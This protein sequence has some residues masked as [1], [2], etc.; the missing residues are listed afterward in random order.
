MRKNIAYPKILL[1]LLALSGFYFANCKTA[2]S[3]PSVIILENGSY[4]N[5]KEFVAFK[6]IRV[7]DGK[8]AAINNAISKEKGERINVHGKYVIPGL[9]DA[10]VHI[11]GSPAYPYVMIDHTNNLKSSLQCGLTTVVDLFFPEDGCKELK[12]TIEPKPEAYASI[13]LSG[14]ILTA[15]EG[16]G[17]EYGV[18]TRTITSVA[19][20][21]KITNEVIDNGMDV[22]KVVYQAYTNPHSLNKEELG[23]II[24][25]A[26]KRNKKVFVHIDDAAGAMDCIDAKADV[27][28]H[29]PVDSMT[30]EQLSKMKKSGIVVIPTI[31]VMQSML[32]GHD[33]AYMSDSLLWKTA[34][35]HYLEKFSP[36][37][38][39]KP[40]SSGRLKM[41]HS[42]GYRYNLS[43]CIEMKI[44]ILAGTDAGN[45][46]V[47]CGYSL[48]NEMLQY[49]NAGMSKAEALCSATENLALV[50]PERKIG[51]VVVGYDADLTILNADPLDNIQNTKS[52]EM[53]VHKGVMMQKDT[54]RAAAKEPEPAGNF[55]PA[56]LNID[57][58]GA[59]S[60]SIHVYS[61]SMLGG[62]S[63]TSGELEKDAGGTFLHLWGKIVRK[64]YLGF[65]GA[66]F[67][68]TTK[69][70]IEAT[71]ISE[72]KA[73]EFDVKGNEESYAV[74]LAS[75]L[76]KDYNYH[77][78]TFK[79][80]KEW[81]TVRVNFSDM[82]QNTY[83]GKQIALDLKTIEA[84]N[85]DMSYKEADIDLEIKNVHL[86]K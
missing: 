40:P 21:T 16:H 27:L 46:A 2:N 72:Y 41:Y 61:D 9:I 49:V 24:A 82:K 20:A 45:Y 48:H 70:D 32:E 56:S 59:L 74:K 55:N 42:I 25:T 19:E 71:D 47:F 30:N 6:E 86:I 3:G 18:P 44:P 52:V 80:A 67:L 57:A 62:L 66:S 60:P 77:A 1:L 15:P 50:L 73:I 13:I 75:A 14:P 12:A 31:T 28:A 43:K 83:Y 8:I 85:F 39:P 79:P 5:G 51:K 76:V 64:G 58:S 17:T 84:I 10:H 23:A 36:V 33:A 11:S 65:G 68:L 7:K 22:I 54:E 69:S 34:D 35:P 29:M 26:H 78:A 37:A 53:V 63:R 81:K 38:L 4:F